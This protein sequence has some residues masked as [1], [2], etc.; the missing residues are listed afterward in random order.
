MI[1]IFVDKKLVKKCHKKAC[2]VVSNNTRK[3][4]RDRYTQGAMSRAK[5]VSINTAG[6]IAEV[7][8]CQFLGIEPEGE[9][10]W[11]TDRPDGGH[12]VLFKGI[13]IDVKASTN[14]FA[15]RLLWPV[16]KIDKLPQAA[17]IFLLARVPENKVSE[18]GQAVQLV[19]WIPRDEFI[20]ACHKAY[21]ISGILQ[22]TPYMN[23]KALYNMNELCNEL[24]A[25]EQQG[26]I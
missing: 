18:D 10:V 24:G 20:H 22:G 6:F 17:D 5:Q 8:L 15:S 7:A 23:E 16:T 26:E 14:P 2:G 4:Y 11:K 9:L 25:K 21:G 19:G 13:R 1:E 12:D 3:N